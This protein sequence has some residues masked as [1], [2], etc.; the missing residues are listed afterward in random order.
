MV[1]THALVVALVVAAPASPKPVDPTVKA[2]EAFVA[3]QRFYK[4]ARYAD[5]IARFEEAYAIQ[6]SPVLFYNIGRCHE[7]LGD[8]PK[9][10]RAYRDYLRMSPD[11]KDKDTVSNAIANLERRLK[12]IGLQ[13]L[14]VFAD[15]PTAVIEVDGK[16]LG[17]SPASVELTAGN[18]KLVV[19]AEGYETTERSFVMQTARATEM[20]I[21]LR[22]AGKP[23]EAPPP[24]P[25]LVDATKRDEPKVATLTP[26]KDVTGTGATDVQQTVPA[27][28]KS[29]LWTWVAG[30][31]AVAAAGAGIGMGVAAQG[32]AARVNDPPM[33]V[34][35][36]QQADG[37]Q[38]LATGANV[39]YGVAAAAAV[40]AVVLFFV[41]GR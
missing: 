37:A 30:G 20:T 9:A 33:G 39:A 7:Q 10:L 24:P 22:E 34:T 12:E 35:P 29:R 28:K 26:S 15:P 14:L 16:V 5:A 23:V 41:E 18:H 31:T 19:K 4:E 25:P 21:N 2:K 38:G 40:T 17:N 8:V 6:P 27:P 32:A 3:G 13:Q 36:R 1:F 11:A